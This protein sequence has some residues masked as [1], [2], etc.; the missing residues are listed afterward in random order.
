[1][2]N[3]PAAAINAVFDYFSGGWGGK[4]FVENSRK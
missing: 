1:M 4:Y 3:S 2:D